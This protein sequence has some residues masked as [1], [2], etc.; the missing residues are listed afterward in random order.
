MIQKINKYVEARRN[1]THE[2]RNIISKHVVDRHHRVT[3]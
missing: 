3:L 2:L 1:T